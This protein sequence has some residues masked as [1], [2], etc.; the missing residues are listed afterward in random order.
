M[1]R[2]IEPAIHYWGTPV[3]LI[4]SLNEDRSTNLSPMSSAWW[5]GWS[6]MLGLDASSKSVENLRRSKAC[7]LN[8]PSDTM[9]VN[10]NGL[11]LT[12]GSR[13]VPIHKKL[14]GYRH[15][16]D[17]FMTAGLTRAPM[18]E[19]WP[20]AVRECPV[21]LES[22]VIQIRPFAVEDSRMAIPAVAVEL[23]VLRVHVDESL[24]TDGH[25]HRIDSDRW[26]PMIM[27]FRQLFGRGAKL[28]KS[29]LA[30]GAEE[31]YAPWKQRGLR[32][33]TGSALSAWSKHKYAAVA[34]SSEE[35]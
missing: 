23:R 17:K 13:N 12:T 10:V 5:L 30:R 9:A 21:Q 6:C 16:A 32:R 8:L 26:H 22:E 15:E 2:M 4:S 35:K 24:L 7:V 25:P 28:E 33:M 19:S 11:A 31:A 34:E 14:L 20:E 27:S 29:T 1:H 18:S 3:V